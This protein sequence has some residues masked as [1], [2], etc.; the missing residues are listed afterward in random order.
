MS[1]DHLLNLWTVHLSGDGDQ[2]FESYDAEDQPHA[3]EQ[4]ENAHPDAKVLAAYRPM[5]GGISKGDTVA[6]RP[7]FSDPGDVSLHWI[8]LTDEEK[9]R[10]DVQPTNTGLRFPPVYTLAADQVM[11]I[12]PDFVRA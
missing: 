4:A 2:W 10:I 1:R 6:I 5:Q 12:H 7:E 3:I 9:G 11:K 8:A